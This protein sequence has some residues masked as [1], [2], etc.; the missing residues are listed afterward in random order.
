[1]GFVAQV[2][3]HVWL[4][5]RDE[6]NT[7][8]LTSTCECVLVVRRTLL[9]NFPCDVT[10]QFLW[11]AMRAQSFRSV[12][13]PKYV[14]PFVCNWPL[15]SCCA[16]QS[17]MHGPINSFI[18]P[19]SR[20][21]KGQLSQPVPQHELALSSTIWGQPTALKEAHGAALP[22][23]PKGKMKVYPSP[24]QWKDCLGLM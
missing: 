8:H 12:H 15:Q 11:S 17:I 9:N 10:G 7:F 19:L 23:Y 14:A 1:M 24:Q 4:S 2:K 21:T 6:R 22:R 16:F 5:L 13:S 20:G 3:L 18:Q